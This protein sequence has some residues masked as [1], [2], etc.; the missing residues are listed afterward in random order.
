[1]NS[2]NIS[3]SPDIGPLIDE[4]IRQAMS[5]QA[6]RKLTDHMAQEGRTTGHQQ[7]ES[8]IQYT[9]LNSRRM[10]RWDKTFGLSEASIGS[11]KSIDLKINWLVLTESWCGDAAPTLPVMN[12]IAELNPNI[13]LGIL[14]RDE[15]LDLMERFRT[16]GALSIP[17]LISIDRESGILLGAWGPRPGK[18]AQ[19]VR[20]Y[21]KEHGALTPE[22]REELQRWYNTDKGI[23]TLQELL[24]LLPLE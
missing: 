18:A 14:L 16:E 21:K 1:M 2:T 22:F 9:V 12:K 5:Y 10:K 4:K 15:H 7:T 3:N 24:E 6:F 11:I 20:E 19:L 23:S 13:Q 17:K 8:L